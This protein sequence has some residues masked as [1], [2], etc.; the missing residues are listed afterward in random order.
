VAATIT[1]AR[2]FAERLKETFGSFKF[3]SGK[4]VFSGKT[5]LGVK[6]VW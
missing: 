4:T 1:A 2:N 5:G 6:P 3:P